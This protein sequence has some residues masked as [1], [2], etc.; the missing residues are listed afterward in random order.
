M[1]WQ[2]DIELNPKVMCGKPVIKGTRLTVELIVELL[3]QGSTEQDILFSYPHLQV[4][5][6]R[7]GLAYAAASLSTDEIILLDEQVA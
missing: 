2:D 1:R 7:A 3:S 5:H 6:I 4:E